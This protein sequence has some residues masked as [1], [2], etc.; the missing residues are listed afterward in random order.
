M[1]AAPVEQRPHPVF[2]HDGPWTEDAYLALPED[3]R[4]ELLDG[5]LLVS[6]AGIGMHQW[7]SSQLW[8]VLTPPPREACGSSRP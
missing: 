3:K 2:D 1:V 6:P 5:S 8:L 4:I 7:L